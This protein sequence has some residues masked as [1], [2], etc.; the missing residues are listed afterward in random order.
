MNWWLC[1]AWG[2]TQFHW[3]FLVIFNKISLQFLWAVG[4]CW[5]SKLSWWW[6]G[7]KW[8]SVCP[9]IT[10]SSWFSTGLQG[11]TT[12]ALWQ[13]FLSKLSLSIG[14]VCCGW[15]RLYQKLKMEPFFYAF[16][17]S[18]LINEIKDPFPCLLG[19]WQHPYVFI[20]TKSPLKDRTNC[21]CSSYALLIRLQ[22]EKLSK[23]QWK[24]HKQ[25]F[26]A[27]KSASD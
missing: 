14:N 18:C 5:R 8:P 19:A 20:V 16:F 11:N 10:S 4:S 12:E 27:V 22:K 3:F 7:Q 9:I 25:V 17:F 1:R 6:W 2:P 23:Q 21:C 24:R 13:L 26:V 15:Q